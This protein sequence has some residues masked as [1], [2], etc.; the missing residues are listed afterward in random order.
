MGAVL[1]SSSSACASVH[2]SSV[3][4]APNVCLCVGTPVVSYAHICFPMALHLVHYVLKVLACTRCA[5][6][7]YI[8]FIQNVC[9]REAMRLLHVRI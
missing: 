9:T 4:F 2:A 8:S 7:H 1:G 3:L 5:L 6:Q